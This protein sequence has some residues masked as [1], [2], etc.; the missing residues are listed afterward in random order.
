[1]GITSR[2][3]SSA[4]RRK[5]HDAAW[6][7]HEAEFAKAIFEPVVLRPR[8]DLDDHIDVISRSKVGGRLVG[9][10]QSDGRATDEDDVSVDK[11][12]QRHCRGLQ[13]LDRHRGH[14]VRSF[15][16][17]PSSFAARF[18]SRAAPIRIAST[19]ASSSCNG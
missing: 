10:P 2:I 14:A 17:A 16:R 11:R 5:R 13:H 7:V 4:G 1:M 12:S 15:R 19:R 18:L 6:V 3:R 8:S 9:G